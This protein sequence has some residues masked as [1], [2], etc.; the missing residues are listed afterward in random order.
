MLAG[1]VHTI[2]EENN[3]LA[4]SNMIKF[5]VYDHVDC[6]VEFSAVAR[7]CLANRVLQSAAVAGELGE[8][9]YLVIERDHHH[10]IVPVQLIDKSNRGILDLL[11]FETRRAA[12]VDHQDHIEGFI[13]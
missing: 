1:C 7:S 8:N 5:L 12:C 10:A 6:F 9:S 2:R 13:D 3:R 4:S 11:Q